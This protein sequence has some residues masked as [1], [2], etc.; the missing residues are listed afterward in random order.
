MNTKPIFIFQCKVVH[1][2]Y[3]LQKHSVVPGTTNGACCCCIRLYMF[4]F[5]PSMADLLT[6]AFSPE[7]ATI[8]LCPVA[9]ARPIRAKLRPKPAAPIFPSRRDSSSSARWTWVRPFHVLS[10]RLSSFAYYRKYGSNFVCR[11]ERK[12]LPVFYIVMCRVLRR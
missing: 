2:V 7:A 6:I 10:C 1:A 8:T 9:L 3:V 4:K 11:R 12:V 5:M